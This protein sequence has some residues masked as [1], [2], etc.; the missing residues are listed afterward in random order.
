M[1]K[2][3]IWLVLKQRPDDN[4]ILEDTFWLLILGI[5]VFKTFLFTKRPCEEEVLSS[6]FW[7]QIEMVVYVETICF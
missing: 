3:F 5:K 2:K 4:S 6:T 7:F 1:K